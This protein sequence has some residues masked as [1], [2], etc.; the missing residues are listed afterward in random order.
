MVINLQE[1]TAGATKNSSIN[2]G[3]SGSSSCSSKQQAAAA[4]SSSSSSSSK[5]QA[6][7]KIQPIAIGLKALNSGQTQYKAF[8][9]FKNLH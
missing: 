7:K 2:S 8:F 3:G 5:Q 4:S 6:A 9:S 1:A